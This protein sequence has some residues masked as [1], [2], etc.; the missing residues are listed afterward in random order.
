[1]LL[2]LGE[3]WCPREGECSG[4]ERGEHPDRNDG[5]VE[6]GAVLWEVSPK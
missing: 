5:L 4:R 1:M 6:L 2:N 3:N